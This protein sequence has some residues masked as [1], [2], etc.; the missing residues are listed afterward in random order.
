M[1]ENEG[2]NKQKGNKQKKFKLYKPRKK[3]SVEEDAAIQ[4]LQAQYDKVWNVSIM[5]VSKAYS[6]I[7]G[8]IITIKFMSYK[9]TDSNS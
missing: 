8:H 1:T 7:L 9:L 6:V 5:L 4:Y 3:K 2:K